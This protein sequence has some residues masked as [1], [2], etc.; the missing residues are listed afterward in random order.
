MEKLGR[1]DISNQQMG[2]RIYIRPVIIAV[3]QQ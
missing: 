1:E 2:I 3:L